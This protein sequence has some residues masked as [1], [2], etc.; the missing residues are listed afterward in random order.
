MLSPAQVQPVPVVRLGALALIVAGCSA[1]PAPPAPPSILLP[2]PV[3]EPASSAPAV[4]PSATASATAARP[5]EP[6]WVVDEDG[7]GTPLTAGLDAAKLPPLPCWGERVYRGDIGKAP[8]TVKIATDGAR[9]SGLAHYDVAGSALALSGTRRG[10]AFTIDEKGAGRF[11]GKCDPATG[12]LAGDYVLRGKLSAFSLAP[13]PSGEV[14]IHEVHEHLDVT[15]PVPAYCAKLGRTTETVTVKER[16]CLPTDPKALAALQEESSVGL[17]HLDL[18]APRVFGLATPGAESLANAALSQDRFQ[19]ASREVRAE[20]KRCPLGGEMS[21]NGG[22]SLVYN[23]DDVLSVYF[24]GFISQTNAAHGAAIGPEPVVVDLRSGKRLAI[25]DVV[26]DEAAFRTA[27]LAC[28]GDDEDIQWGG[29][30]VRSAPRWVVV[31]GGIAV[32]VGS[33]PPIKNGAQGRGPMA[34][35]ASLLRHKL[36]RADSPVARLWAGVAPAAKDT[37]F[38]EAM[39]GWGEILAM[40]RRVPSP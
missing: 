13:R 12:Q 2:A 27:I 11:V 39:M 31:P 26:S 3:A 22:F 9:L 17:C 16:F 18:R 29:D 4:V 25:G 7:K 24:S 20:V 1:A 40:R 37:P 8:V 35:F 6:E 10:D 32:V 36:L 5:A 30:A 21:T 15:S 33:V 34:S 38:C 28:Y 23:A 19:Y 14:A